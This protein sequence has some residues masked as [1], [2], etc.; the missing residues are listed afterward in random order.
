MSD[1]TEQEKPASGRKP[2]TLTRTTSGGT[3][4]QSFSHGRRKSVTVE[5]KEKRAINRPGQGGAAPAPGPGLPPA[6]PR[7]SG[8]RAAPG[9]TA[10]PAPAKAAPTSPAAPASTFSDD[11]ARRRQE[12]IRRAA[13]ERDVREAKARKDEQQRRALEDAQRKKAEEEAAVEAERRRT[14]EDVDEPEAVAAAPQEAAED[15]AP[16]PAAEAKSEP[17]KPAG[18]QLGEAVP[19]RARPQESAGG[20]NDILAEL[21]GRLKS[22]RKPTAPVP[23]KPAKKGEARRREG[24]L[25]LDMVE[26]I[27]EGDD[28]RVRSLAAY[29]RAQ[30]K[31]R[32]RRQQKS[33]GQERIVREVVIPEAITVQDLANRMAMRARDIIAFLMRQGQMAK[34]TDVLDADTAELV[35]TEFGHSVKR[36]AES[37]VEEGL[38]GEPDAEETLL[39]RPPVVTIMGH[40]DHGKT[41]LLD[42]LRETDVASGEAGGIT[43]HIGAYQVRLRDGQ[44]I[45]FLDTPGHAAFSSMRARG[46]QV[47]DIVI[48]VV[49]ADDGVMP[50]TVEAISHAREAKVP[51]IVAVNK[52]DKP[53]AKPERV[54]QELLQHEIVT[55]QF[56]GDVLHVTVSATKKIGLDKLTDTILLQSELLDLRANPDRDGEAVVVES[57]LDRGRGPVATVLM[58]RGTLKRGDI[59]VA[60][61]Q[62]GRVRALS[63]ERGQLVEEAGPSEPVEI[64][65]L[66]GVPEPGGVVQAVES[67]NRAREIA[68]YRQR[69]RRERSVAGV[70]PKTSLEQMMARIKESVTQEL[71]VLIKADVQGSAE[72]IA[73]ALQKLGTEEVQARIVQANVG[74]INES[75]VQLAKSSGAPILGFNVRAS[76]EARELAER[77]GVEIRYYAIIYDLIDDM[78]GV[79]SGLLAPIN[80][81]TFLGNADVLEVFNISKVGKVAGCRVTE[82]VVRKGAKVRIL[83]DNIVIQEMGVLQTLKRFKDEVNEVNAGQECG[84]S[85]GAF[86]DIKQGDVIE[87]FNVEVVQ[88]SL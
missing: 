57:K 15:A 66:E 56:G 25:T 6:S 64:M 80:R 73:G 52:I 75:D 84:M 82:G 88:R 11:E 7:P 35:A 36:V 68:E 76:K 4:Q 48:L 53:D 59:V 33:G 27:S 85:F 45:T 41:S 3:V 16:A 17:A 28:E 70:G 14:H 71:P 19:F 49:A 43:Q 9:A 67:E 61:G 39:P 60:G 78:R 31:E 26:R 72:A 1:G 29:R 32:E 24:K 69:V 40:V 22:A 54:L 34:L 20:D 23:V 58:K 18:P 12:A 63:N 65:G 51:I 37:D 44:R 42:S 47:T 55:E 38:S 5:V 21:G 79:M 81:E 86:Q 83:R 77:E 50:Q 87:C 2:L 74:A 62:W 8:G 13:E 46:A 30:Q 10:K